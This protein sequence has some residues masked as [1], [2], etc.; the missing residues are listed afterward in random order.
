MKK[1]YIIFSAD[2]HLNYGS[3]TLEAVCTSADEAFK[4]L[5]PI[6][7]REAGKVYSDKGYKNAGSM[8]DDLLSNLKDLRQTQTL[9]INYVIKEQQLNAFDC[10]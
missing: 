7:V 8:V 9:D 10:I 1:V 6:L 2:T 3:Y 5:N 4:L